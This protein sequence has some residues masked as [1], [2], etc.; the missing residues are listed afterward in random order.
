M[1]KK[2]SK[3]RANTAY[4]T[5][6][7]VRLM[8]E[9]IG[10]I[11]I[12]KMYT[13]EKPFTKLIA[14]SRKLEIQQIRGAS[15]L[16][17]IIMSFALFSTRFSTFISILTFVLMGND[18]NAYYVFV[19]TS[20]YNSLRQVMTNQL[21]Q[22]MTLLAELNVSIRRI[23]SLLEY[24]EIEQVK[25]K[26]ENIPNSSYLGEQSG[27]CIRNA[28]AK[29]DLTLPENTL[30][31]VS[32]TVLKGE[33][34]AV[35]GSV[36]SGKSSLLQVILNELPLN[37]GEIE[38]KGT[39]SYAAQEPWLFTGSIR[40]NILFGQ[41]FNLDRYN[42]V[43]KACALER[44]FSLFPFGDKSVVGERGVLLSGGQKARIGLARA[45]YKEAD[46]YLL[47]DPLSAVD[48]HVGKQLFEN[49]INELLKQKCVILVTHQLQYLA[50]VDNIMVLEN[51]HVAAKG[52]YE[53]LQKAGY[54]GKLS[55]SEGQKDEQEIADTDKITD[56]K[57][58]E[59]KDPKEVKEH[60]SIGKVANRI[61]MA[62]VRAGGGLCV[63]A[64]SVTC[65][66]FAQ[67]SANGADYFNT[68]W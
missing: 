39:I 23:Q 38:V 29:W 67:I 68:F 44:D 64:L 40:Q 16:K 31:D 8:N 15:Y 56:N 47:D 60:K 25:E 48:T 34:V 32:L 50:S 66:L 9:I 61:Y 7:R 19:I 41:S 24:E 11:K 52:S 27:I 57:K 58:D 42:K 30:S 4:R 3:F 22:G 6:E 59:R 1:A 17:G 63:V 45:V 55:K 14:T 36:G 46:V 5:D 13:W 62:Y 65:F 37:E 51:G 20:F 35:I 43:V 2:I 53:E 54:L 33:L 18:P 49:C 12:I 10:G 28:T 21:P 26:S